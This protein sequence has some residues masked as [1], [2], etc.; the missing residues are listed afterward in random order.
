MSFQICHIN[1]RGYVTQNQPDLTIAASVSKARLRVVQAS[2]RPILSLRWPVKHQWSCCFPTWSKNQIAQL[3]WN[4]GISMFITYCTF[5]YFQGKS[6]K[7]HHSPSSKVRLLCCRS[8]SRRAWRFSSH[9]S[10]QNCDQFGLSIQELKVEICWNNACN[11]ADPDLNGFFGQNIDKHVQNQLKF[12]TFLR[13][14][15][16]IWTCSTVGPLMNHS[17]LRWEIYPKLS[18]GMSL[19][20]KPYLP[21]WSSFFQFEFANIFHNLA[22][23]SPCSIK[24]MYIKLF[25]FPHLQSYPCVYKYTYIVINR[26]IN[27]TFKLDYVIKW[28]SIYIYGGFLKNGYPQIIQILVGFSIINNP[29]IGVPPFQETPI[30]H[31][32]PRPRHSFGEVLR[33]FWSFWS[34]ASITKAIV[35]G[36]TLAAQM[37]P[38]LLE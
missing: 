36:L 7:P 31:C 22:S 23:L 28:C 38:I 8:F 10:V 21:Y 11:L 9:A 29:A 5:M 3:A 33:C 24:S 16:H 32:S 19:H 13:R 14:P 37:C 2:G 17:V 27:H 6:S 20:T 1:W 15:W 18:R 30:Y 25:E 4:P 12:P 34:Y 26:S 35:A